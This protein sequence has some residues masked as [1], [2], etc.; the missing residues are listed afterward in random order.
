M[1]IQD[2]KIVQTSILNKHTIEF[3]K[4]NIFLMKV[5]IYT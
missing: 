3:D 2:L 1:I 4:H 5:F